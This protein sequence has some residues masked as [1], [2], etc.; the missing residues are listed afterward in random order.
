M[1]MG[2]ENVDVEP[3]LVENDGRF[4]IFPI[5]HQDIWDYYKKH[6]AAF[7]IAEEVDLTDDLRDWEDLSEKEQFFIKQVL[8]FFAASDGIVNENLA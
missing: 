3:I 5:Q 8:A 1:T 4:V 2:Q 6:Q 7:W